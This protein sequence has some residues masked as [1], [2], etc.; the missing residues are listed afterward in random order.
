MSTLFCAGDGHQLQSGNNVTQND[1]S[2]KDFFVFE[3]NG[4]EDYLVKASGTCVG[5]AQL[6]SNIL[7]NEA[8]HDK[9]GA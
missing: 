2:L 6:L 8:Q 9:I 4:N 3:C 7:D 5:A 1:R